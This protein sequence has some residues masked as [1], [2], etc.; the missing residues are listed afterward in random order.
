[1]IRIAA[2]SLAALAGQDARTATT[3]PRAFSAKQRPRHA[4]NRRRQTMAGAALSRSQPHR[5]RHGS[6]ISQHWSR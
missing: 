3:A 4:R 5:L 6:G 2:T 1:V